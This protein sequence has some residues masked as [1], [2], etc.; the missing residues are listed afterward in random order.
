DDLRGRTFNVVIEPT[1]G[2][3]RFADVNRAHQFDFLSPGRSPTVSQGEGRVPPHEAGERAPRTLDSSEPPFYLARQ[4]N[5]ATVEVKPALDLTFDV[6]GVV[7][8]RSPR[9]ATFDATPRAGV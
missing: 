2:E 9:R 1:I 3:Q 8:D 5:G 6:P 4:G 7:S